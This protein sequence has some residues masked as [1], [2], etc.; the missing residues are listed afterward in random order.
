MKPSNFFLLLVV[1]ALLAACSQATAT[2]PPATPQVGAEAVV[3]EGH[4]VPRDDAYLTFALR[5]KVA[6]VLVQK[7]DVVEAGQVLARLG[8]REPAE[9]TLAAAQLE[10]AAAQLELTNAQQ[11]YDTLIRIAS[12]THAQAWVKYNEAQTARAT[13]DRAWEAFD[14]DALETDLE[15]A[16]DEVKTRETELQDAQDEFDKYKALTKDNERRKTAKNVLDTAQNNYNE[17]VRKWEELQRRQDNLQAARDAAHAA[18]AEAER[19]FTTTAES[20]VSDAL[21]LAQARLDTV[22]VRLETA[23]AQ[24]AAAQTNLNNYDL[25]APF[26]GTV[27]DLSIAAGESVGTDKWVVQLADFSIQYVE[28][29]DL[30]ELEVVKIEVGQT[31]RL[32]PDALPELELQGIV[33]SIAQAAKM[34]SG[35]VLYTVKI[36]VDN[37]DPRLRWGMTFEATFEP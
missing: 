30:N 4:L 3:A 34:Q 33:E 20:A 29:S 36:N 10:Q 23:A 28:T 18:E 14:T 35:D 5:G 11:A 26:A 24:I 12:L 31:V 16:T 9:A 17:A 37:V 19:L 2:P 13:A 32:V 15:T 25:K 6:E 1:T 7:G 27:T 21:T 8:D 22:K